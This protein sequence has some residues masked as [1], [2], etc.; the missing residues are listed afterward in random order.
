MESNPLA[1]LKKW[2]EI[3]KRAFP[4]RVSTTPYR[5]WIS[6]VMLQQTLAVVVVPYF[7]NWMARFPTIKDLAE[8]PIEPVIKTWEGLGYYSRA[9]NLHSGAKM[10]AER[11]GGKIPDSKEE[12]LKI[13]GIGDYTAA[14]ILSFAF[15]QKEAAVDGNVKRVISRLYAMEEDI[16]KPRTHALIKNRVMELLPDD[17]PWEAM[18]ALIELGA[19]VCKKKPDCLECPLQNHCRAFELGMERRLPVKTAAIRYQTLHRT[20]IV[21]RKGASILVKKVQEGS[22]MQDLHEFP[23]IETG[24]NGLA[25]SETARHIEKQW[26]LTPRFK[27]KLPKVKHSFTRFRAELTPLVYEASGTF[28]G[29]DYFWVRLDK[30]CRLPFSSGHKR[31]LKQLAG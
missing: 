29:G 30:A 6:E 24:E 2:F 17:K 5:V 25:P 18:E 7:E 26:N 8:A 4:W 14:A 11:H 31:I 16:G 12:L 15:K 20:V 21:L 28:G 3:N 10:I 27:E 9:R 19:V 22:V 1:K 23:Y 13:K